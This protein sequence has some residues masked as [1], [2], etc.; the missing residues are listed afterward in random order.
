MTPAA[1]RRCCLSMPEA[2]EEF[3]FGPETSVFKVRG[4]MFALSG[5][6]RKPLEVSV[7]CDPEL[8]EQLRHAY[9]AVQP[10]FHLNKRHWNTVT[11]DGTVEDRLVHD[12]VEDSWDLVV[13]GLP[14]RDRARLRDA[15]DAN[16]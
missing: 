1:L 7:K 12:M 4:K 15:A 14:K 6:E 13:D 10:G 2:Y 3:P 16:A 9:D 5:L 8:A 11:L